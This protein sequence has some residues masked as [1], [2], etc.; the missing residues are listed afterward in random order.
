MKF[1]SYTKSDTAYTFIGENGEKMIVPVK[2]IIL[3]D[4]NSGAIAV[5]N[6]ASRCVLGYLNK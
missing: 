5:K 2:D 1:V 4:D 3:V 6:T